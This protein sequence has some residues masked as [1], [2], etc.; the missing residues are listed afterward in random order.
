MNRAIVLTMIFL[1][2]PAGAGITTREQADAALARLDRAVAAAPKS[3]RHYVQRGNVYYQLNDF[4]RAVENYNTALKLDDTQDQAYFGRGMAYG[5]MG[6][7]DE[8]IADLD[9]YITRHPTDSNAYT[10]RGVRNIWRGNLPDA[11]RDFTRAIELDPNNAEAHDDLGVVYAK[12]NRLSIAAEH[13]LTAIRLDPSYQKAYHN[14]AICRFIQ[15]Q[16]QSALELVDRG[17]LLDADNR[18]SLVL[19]SSIL[20]SLGRQ[21]EA[22]EILARAEFLPEENWSER[23]AIER[24]EK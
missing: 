9:V 17:L 15:G 2:A 12:Y 4:H 18:S 8:G 22:N 23:S 14:L 16:P 24:T 20:Q 6:L 19:K 10:K 11:Q 21:T 1:L 7:I 3:A 13:F 5:R